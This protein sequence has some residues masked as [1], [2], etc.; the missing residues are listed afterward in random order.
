MEI[1]K[2]GEG[3]FLKNK[4]VFL[5]DRDNKDKKTDKYGVCFDSEEYLKRCSVASNND[6]TGMVPVAMKESENEE[7]YEAMFNVPVG[8]M[9]CKDKKHSRK[10]K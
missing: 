7:S 10:R 3:I 9:E 4:S 6:H 1:N 5:N 2:F 8:N